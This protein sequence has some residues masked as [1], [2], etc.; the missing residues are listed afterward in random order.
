MRTQGTGGIESGEKNGIVRAIRISCSLGVALVSAEDSRMTYESV[1]S[2]L[3]AKLSVC[4][5]DCETGVGKPRLD[6]PRM[7]RLAAKS[8]AAANGPSRN[9]G[10]LGTDDAL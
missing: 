8:H 7:V 6:P 4:E 5:C 10:G 9:V 2:I 1:H 3:I